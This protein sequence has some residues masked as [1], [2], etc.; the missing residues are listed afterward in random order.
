MPNSE[1]SSRAPVVARKPGATGCCAT[2]HKK[3]NLQQLLRNSYIAYTSLWISQ[4][5][6]EQLAREHSL[7]DLFV[8]VGLE[9]SRKFFAL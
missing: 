7:L 4:L 1:P 9:P 3:Q 6:D 5:D 2:I 8:L